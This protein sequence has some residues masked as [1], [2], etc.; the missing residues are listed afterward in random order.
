MLPTVHRE[1]GFQFRIFTNDHSPP[2]VHVVMVDAGLVG[3]G[4]LVELGDVVA[5]KA[6]GFGVDERPSM[7]K[8]VG[9]AIQDMAAAASAL[10]RARGEGL[11]QEVQL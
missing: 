5:G 11:G 2:H 3:E 9:L 6:R 8:S 4:D 10:E 1:G 7:F